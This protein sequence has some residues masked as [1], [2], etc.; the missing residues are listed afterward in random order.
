MPCLGEHRDHEQ[1]DPAVAKSFANF[2][3]AGVSQHAVHPLLFGRVHTQATVL[4]IN[5]QASRYSEARRSTR[6]PGGEN[7]VALSMSSAIR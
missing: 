7:L 6:P 4:D 1:A 3:P 5:S 2:E